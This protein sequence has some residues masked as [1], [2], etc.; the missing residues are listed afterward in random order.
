L[1]VSGW[2]VE[3]LGESE[4]PEASCDEPGDGIALGCRSDL[5]FVLA[6]D[7]LQGGFIKAS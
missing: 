2:P 7:P 5:I 1:T 3:A 4:E 6:L